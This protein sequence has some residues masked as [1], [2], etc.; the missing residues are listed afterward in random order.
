MKGPMFRNPA[1]VLLAASLTLASPAATLEIPQK[2]VAQEARTR[3]AFTAG[4]QARAKALEARLSS[5]MSIQDANALVRGET[6]GVAFAV[7]MA[8]L[9]I[10][11]KEARADRTSARTSAEL[12]LAAKQGKLE[13][14]KAKIDAM[15]REAAE[16][17]DNAMSAARVGTTIGIVSCATALAGA[18][19]S[20]PADLRGAPVLKKTPT[21]SVPRLV[22]PG[23]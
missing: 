21:P 11:Q 1:A 15:K 7:L 9:R 14:E 8:Y 22:V 19:T 18:A 16:R 6:A 3:A 2:A 20:T 4:E 17:F 12:E 10:L 5:R 13:A 23:S